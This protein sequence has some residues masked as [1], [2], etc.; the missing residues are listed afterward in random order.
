MSLESNT[1]LR[2]LFHFTRDER[3]GVVVLLI[4]CVI[5][6]ILPKFIPLF[7]K[8]ERVD[9]T[10]YKT[11]ITAFRNSFV[12]LDEEGS[13]GGGN[14]YHKNQYAKHV[15]P[16]DLFDFDPNTAN[17]AD[18]MKLGLSQKTAATILKYRS[19]GGKFRSPD[20][21]GKI[22]SIRPEQFA[23]LKPHIKIA[24]SG[25]A[26]PN[27]EKK[28]FEKK[29]SFETF[30]FD[31]NTASE[32]DLGRLFPARTA[33]SIVNFRSKGGKF[34]TK[35]DLKKIY[36][37]SEEDFARVESSIAIVASP[38]LKVA[39]KEDK[40][41][42]VLAPNTNAGFTKSKKTSNKVD[43]NSATVEDFQQL[44]GIGVGYAARFVNTREKLGGFVK[45]EQL[46]ETYGLADSVFQK[47]L[48]QL[49]LGTP[50]L[51]KLK[52]NGMSADDLRKHPYLGWK[53]A[54]MIVS[55][56]EQHGRYKSA[57]DLKQIPL[58][59]PEVYAKI[60]EYISLE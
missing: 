50:T 11:E 15:L 17:E 16:A 20:D 21:F 47:I 46:K 8:K 4:L 48:P 6:A 25:Y 13:E 12:E 19:K 35:E 18:F 2:D 52:I 51:R 14:G 26:K 55:Y 53:I 32:A 39:P 54:N 23:Q 57:A 22:Y 9:F 24:E 30:A 10:A 44:P 34:R 33:Q 60:V 59:T 3:R 49:Q 58:I 36:T 41:G 38:N 27:F 42:S 28:G 7:M 37:L 29:E 45:I 5:F 40:P 1:P 43:I 31:P 56:R